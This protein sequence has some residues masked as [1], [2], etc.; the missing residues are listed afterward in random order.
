M[1]LF[2]IWHHSQVV[3][4]GSAK[5]SFPGPNPGGASKIGNVRKN[6]ADFIYHLFT[7]HYSLKRSSRFW[8]VIRNS[9]EL[10]SHVPLTRHLKRIQSVLKKQNPHTKV[11]G[12][13][14]FHIRISERAVRRLAG[15]LFCNIRGGKGDPV[16]RWDFWLNWREIYDII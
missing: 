5:P 11:S 15:G 13:L 7:I 9:E 10:R 2:S 16:G 12:F 3:R 6:I 4:Q 14:L 1:L 8:K